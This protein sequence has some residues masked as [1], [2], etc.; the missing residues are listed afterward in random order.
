MISSD[1]LSSFSVIGWKGEVLAAKRLFRAPS[2]ARRTSRTGEQR[3]H[4]SDGNTAGKSSQTL[5]SVIR[6]MLVSTSV[7]LL[8]TASWVKST[9][10][11]HIP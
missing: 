6:Q 9:C 7:Q 2:A 5:V 8:L 3:Q 10:F 1:V 11:L 4:S